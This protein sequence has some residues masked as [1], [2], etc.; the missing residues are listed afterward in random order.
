MNKTKTKKLI[1][2]VKDNI[3][4]HNIDINRA[5]QL[6]DTSVSD[7]LIYKREKLYGYLWEL[8]EL[9]ETYE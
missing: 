1:K 6:D 5:L 2:E 8:E 4:T 7:H 9:L 3:N